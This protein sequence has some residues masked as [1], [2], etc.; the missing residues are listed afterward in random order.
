M[1]IL[2]ESD[3]NT[4]VQSH[5]D[6][7]TFRTTIVFL[8]V[9]LLSFGWLLII[10]SVLAGLLNHLQP[11]PDACLNVYEPAEWSVV[12]WLTAIILGILSALP[13]SVHHFL[14][15]A[16]P[17]L[18]P[19]EFRALRRWT[20]GGTLGLTLLSAGMLGW[21]FP[22]AYD[23]GHQ[24]H[25]SVNL[26]AQYN[27]VDILLYAV[28]SVWMLMIFTFT[29]MSL[30]FLGKGGMLNQQTAGFWRW[31]IY[32][33]GTV[34]L[35]LSV[36]ERSTGFGLLLLL[37]YWFSSE[38]IGSRWFTLIPNHFGISKTRLDHEGRK[39]RILIAD[40][41]CLGANAHYGTQPIEGYSMMRFSGIC[42]SKSDRN[43]LM[44]HVLNNNISDVVITGCDGSP[45]PKRLREN[46][47]Q[48]GTSLRGFDLMGLQN[49]RPGL[50]K[51]P[52]L[53]LE[54]SL[55]AL[56]DPF[57]EHGMPQRLIHLMNENSLIPD[58]ILLCEDGPLGWSTF[59]RDEMLLIRIGRESSQWTPMANLIS[60]PA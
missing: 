29:W 26:V 60:D 12:R 18:L 6:E 4:P 50:P 28:L 54:V 38:T 58:E 46:F 15:F 51:R 25:L 1:S 11:C 42:A 27:A 40:C 5:F 59:Q 20:L 44:E 13:L 23:A 57:P 47:T 22:W 36:P 21:L 3:A 48:L 30:I 35:L 9:V 2:L 7:L 53:D 56:N 45:C 17:G 52:Q 19:G 55:V 32:G 14:Q 8:S 16:K 43:R 31:R 33:F 10:D 49:H 37:I 41:S 24:H 39:R 34:L